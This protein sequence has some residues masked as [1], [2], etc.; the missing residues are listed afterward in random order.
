MKPNRKIR[1]L[2][3]LTLAGLL[4]SGLALAE[5]LLPSARGYVTM[6][7]D[8]KSKQVVLFGGQTGTAGIRTNTNGETWA[9]AVQDNAWAQMFPKKKPNAKSAAQLAYDAESNRVIM[10]GGGVWVWGLAS[11]ETWAYNYNANTWIKMAYGP[12]NH[13]G[14][15]LAYDSESDRMIL[16]GGL[17]AG[18]WNVLDWFY[19]DDTWAYDYNS[20]TWTEMKP[21]VSP[22]G[23][24]YQAMTYDSKVDRVLTWGGMYLDESPLP[25]SMWAY[26]FNS[27]T[28]MEFPAGDRPYPPS[29]DYPA[30]AYDAQ[31]DRTILFGGVAIPD[32]AGVKEDVGTWAYDYT[33]HTWEKMNPDPEPPFVSRHALVYSAATDRVILFGGETDDD[34][35]FTYTNA[36]WAY[37]YDSNTWTKLTP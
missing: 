9:Y 14:G 16:F 11:E 34:V 25:E 7:Y 29:R 26:D 32:L 6:A 17:N 2:V 33:T 15:R 31:S 37:D 24:N 5:D 30:M 4:I 1:L 13:L 10:Y 3:W 35:Q 23:R 12:K 36:T 21:A 20:D 27:N 8:A 28:W 19:C 18:G 22:P